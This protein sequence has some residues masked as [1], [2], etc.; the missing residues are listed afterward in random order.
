MEQKLLL[1]R[2]E[3]ARLLGISTSTLARLTQEG[4]LPCVFIG[5]RVLFDINDV[6]RFIQTR[7]RKMVKGKTVPCSE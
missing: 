7:K 5:V 4:H 2:T 3:T 1:S 6:K